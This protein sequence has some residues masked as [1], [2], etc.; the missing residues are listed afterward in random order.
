MF[1]RFRS[2]PKVLLLAPLGLFALHP[3]A[4][5]GK[6][7]VG[8]VNVQAV[9]S[10]M[11]SGTG[12]VALSRKSDADLQAQVRAVQALMSRANARTASAADKSAYAA[13]AKKYQASA[14]SYQ[15][16]LASSF[17]PLAGRVNTA[18]ASVARAGGYSVV[19]DQ[20]V[21]R[22]NR[23]VIYANAQ[24]TDLTAAVTAKVKG[25]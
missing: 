17:A 15:K 11:P 18:V 23:L 14:Q 4:Q 20:R 13:A 6:N 12:F 9:V 7:R 21:A 1:K 8:I 25:K 10:A 24:A 19:L 16:Q 3:Q 2:V 5:Q 22:D